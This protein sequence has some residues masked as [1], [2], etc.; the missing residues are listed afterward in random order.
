MG[1]A[2]SGDKSLQQ[3]QDQNAQTQPPQSTHSQNPQAQETHVQAPK[4]QAKKWAVEEM[5]AFVGVCNIH[6]NTCVLPRLDLYWTTKHPFL[7]THLKD[8]FPKARFLAICL[9]LA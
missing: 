7:E 6:G 2:R 1:I 5:K 4:T 3:C 8:I 9:I